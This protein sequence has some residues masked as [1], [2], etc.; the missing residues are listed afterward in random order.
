MAD[1]EKLQ[2]MLDN[3][4]NQKAEQAQVNFH[5]YLQSKM[6]EVAKNEVLS[7]ASKQGSEREE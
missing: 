4:I 3:L 7:K 1:R 6:Q 5:D 2:N